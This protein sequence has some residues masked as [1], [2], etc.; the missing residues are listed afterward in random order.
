MKSGS[1]VRVVCAMSFVLPLAVA[2]PGD[3]DACGSA[4]YR[5]FENSAPIEDSAALVAGAE[6]ALRDGNLTLAAEK[7]AQAFPALKLIKPGTIP[8]ADR[9][10]RVLALASVRN[11]GDIVA[12]TMRA[13]SA[14]DR[15]DNLEWSIETLRKLSSKRGDNPAYETD[16]GEALARVPSHHN[17]ATKILG[18]LAAKDLLT[19]AEGYA[20]L[21]RLRAGQGDVPGREAAIKR[22][23]V[24]TR[25]PKIC[26]ISTG[27]DNVAKS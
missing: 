7:A 15:A 8:L 12:S 21:A 27:A 10:L 4:L 14:A 2:A 5:D 19:S 20:A 9:A 24:M 18:K 26:E 6:S 3:A 23:G 17:E 22:C 11:N 1:L 13:S 25:T 16:L